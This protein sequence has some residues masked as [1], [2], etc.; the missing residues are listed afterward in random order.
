ME[1]LTDGGF[2][3]DHVPPRSMQKTTC[4]CS[5]RARV[6]RKVSLKSILAVHL[7]GL[8]SVAHSQA[9][10]PV[11]EPEKTNL[12]QPLPAGCVETTSPNSTETAWEKLRIVMGARRQMIVGS[13]N[14][15]VQGP[16]RKELIYTISSDFSGNEGYII[17]SKTNRANREKSQEFCLDP[18]RVAAYVDN[19]NLQ[20][21]PTMVNRG[22]LGIAL[23]NNHKLGSKVA[24]IGAF[25]QGSLYAVHFNAATGKGAH[26]ESDS[27]GNGFRD[28]AF[29]ENFEYSERMKAVM[30]AV[31][32]DARSTVKPKD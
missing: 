18:A 22:E 14:Q 19:S 3:C 8:T 28:I 32:T 9:K 29:F 2:N 1:L 31:A 21:V 27:Q 5:V 17:R 6:I 23:L 16:E 7:L 13:A 25:S 4:Y 24:V 30:S 26:K 11:I 20:A 12:L 15:I 10:L